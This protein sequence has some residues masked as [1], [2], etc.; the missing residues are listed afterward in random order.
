MFPTRFQRLLLP[1]IH[2]V[3]SPSYS[4]SHTNNLPFPPFPHRSMNPYRGGRGVF[5]PRGGSYKGGGGLW[6]A[7]CALPASHRP[8]NTARKPGFFGG[9]T[10]KITKTLDTLAP[11][12]YTISER[13]NLDNLGRTP[14]HPGGSYAT[15]PPRTSGP[16][17]P[18]A[19][20]HAE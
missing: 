11:W 9:K 12:C 16:A 4:P 5:A 14:H 7:P 20:V 6:F 1:N 19:H 10:K 2:S 8:A 17:W 15:T 13:T 18:G 3:V